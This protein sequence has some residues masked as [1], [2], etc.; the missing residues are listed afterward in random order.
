LKQL[1]SA[2]SEL[3]PNAFALKQFQSARQP[4]MILLLNRYGHY[5]GSSLKKQFRLTEFRGLT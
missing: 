1:F 3:S 4:M 2:N 5:C